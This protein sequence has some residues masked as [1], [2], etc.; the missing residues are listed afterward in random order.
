MG[1]VG[2]DVHGLDADDNGVACEALPRV[3]FGGWV[4]GPGR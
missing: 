3:E 1:Q 2:Y 4:L